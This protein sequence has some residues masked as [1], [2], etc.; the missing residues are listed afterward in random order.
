MGV[1]T[2]VDSTQAMHRSLAVLC[3]TTAPLTR[4]AARNTD[5]NALRHCSSVVPSTDPAGGPP[6]LINAPSS[7][8]KASSASAQAVSAVPASVRSAAS[9]DGTVRSQ[10]AHRFGQQLGPS[11]DEDDARPLGDELLSRCAPQPGTGGRHQEHSV[12]QAKIHDQIITPSRE[13]RWR[14]RA[15]R[16]GLSDRLG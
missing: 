1:F 7:R 14:L 10:S 12:C 4:S 5:S 13:L 3:R 6:T 9:A 11:S 2:E 8:P 15:P 16:V